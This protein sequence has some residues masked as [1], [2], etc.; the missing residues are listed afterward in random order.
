MGEPLPDRVGVEL[1]V[2]AEGLGSTD[3]LATALWLTSPV[4]LL[5]LQNEPLPVRVCEPLPV[6]QEEPVGVL[7][8]TEPV[9]VP[10]PV[11][12]FEDVVE[13]VILWVALADALADS[14]G[15]LVALRVSPL[16][17][18]RADPL[19]VRLALPEPEKEAVS[20]SLKVSVATGVLDT[21]EVMDHPE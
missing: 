3:P 4:E 12:D 7:D 16:A 1:L 17:E 5:V 8:P 6:E 15:L 21:V 10:E 11:W 9:I 2:P 13:D 20:E 19:I 18:A 14:D